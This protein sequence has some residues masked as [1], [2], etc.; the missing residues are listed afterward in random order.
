MRARPGGPTEGDGGARGEKDVGAGHDVVEDFPPR[1]AGEDFPVE[2]GLDEGVP[3][4]VGEGDLRLGGEAYEG[5]CLGGEHRLEKK[6]D[7]VGCGV[8][9]VVYVR[10]YV[11]TYVCVCVCVRMCVCVYV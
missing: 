7:G 2:E 4:G 6:K 5:A 1:A 10:T 11:R 8:V 9:V 3:V